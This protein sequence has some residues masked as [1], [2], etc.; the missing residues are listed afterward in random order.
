MKG[1]GIGFTT[2]AIVV[3]VGAENET[4]PYYDELIKVRVPEIHGLSY[5]P[6]FKTT[7]KDF[8]EDE[9]L[10]WARFIPS[11][12]GI[13]D[14]ILECKANTIGVGD[15]VFV[16]FPTGK[17]SDILVTGVYAKYSESL[18]QGFDLSDLVAKAPEWTVVQV[19]KDE[20]A[21]DDPDDNDDDSKKSPSGDGKGANS[22]KDEYKYFFGYPFA[23]KQ[24]IS[25]A[26]GKKG[27]WAAG[28]HTGIDLSGSI[29]TT[30]YAVG[31]GTVVTAGYDKS[32]G[33]HVII[34]HGT[35][36]GQKLWTLYAHMDKSPSVS[37][38]QKVLGTQ[39]I[40][41]T[42]WKSA[43]KKS[44]SEY[45]KLTSKPKDWDSN[46]TSYYKKTGGTSHNPVCTKIGT[47]QQSGTKLGVRGST[48]NSTG[49]HLH[50]EFR[51]GANGYYNYTNPNQYVKF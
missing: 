12:L 22:Y 5:D 7:E 6:K 17:V 46:F 27:N 25:C 35:V 44:G 31:N 8:T 9:D 23:S 19:P 28:K 16:Q 13:Y 15:E 30:I 36:K 18:Y 45:V 34:S 37:K 41:D 29:G 39:L 3:S 50:F 48:G 47:K 32:Y 10:P 33:N 26:F 14:S 42:E 43:Y 2:R 1:I 51:K 20:E 24:T 4:N 38:G 11:Y 21:P 40:P 49:P